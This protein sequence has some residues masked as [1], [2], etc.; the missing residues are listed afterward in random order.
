[1]RLEGKLAIVTGGA[2][3]IGE[4]I[5]RCLAEEGA[6]VAILDLDGEQAAKTAQAL[7][8]GHAGL[9][10]DVAEE[11]EAHTTLG[12][13]AADVAR[14]AAFFGPRS[15][16]GWQQAKSRL[17]EQAAHFTEVE[18]LVA[19]LGPRLTAGDVVLVKASRGMK[20]ERVV[21][22]LTGTSAAEGSH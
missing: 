2:R 16:G 22:A 17:G 9:Y 20:L 15:A 5:A 1:M 3:G 21:A 7:G 6:R 12:S 8:S 19:W 4:G 14:V 13:R 10:A 18:S 11:S